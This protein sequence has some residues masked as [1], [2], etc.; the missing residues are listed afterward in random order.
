[1]SELHKDL[2]KHENKI[3]KWEAEHE[4]LKSDVYDYLHE[5]VQTLEHEAIQSVKDNL[6]GLDTDEIKEILVQV[7]KDYLVI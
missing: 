4:R 6:H 3:A 5:L 1:M 2:I 7:I